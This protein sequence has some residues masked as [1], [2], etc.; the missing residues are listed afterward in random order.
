MAGE[1]DTL[2]KDVTELN[3]NVA[4]IQQGLATNNLT[5]AKILKAVEGNGGIGLKTQAELNKAAIIRAWW[6]LG[7]L[8]LSILG[9]AV[10]AIRG[11]LLK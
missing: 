11:L 10:F 2:R 3:L 4:L 8:S 6:W 1:E 5:T 9:V 7:G